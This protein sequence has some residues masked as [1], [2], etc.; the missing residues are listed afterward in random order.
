MG[1][2]PIG[3]TIGL[4]PVKKASVALL[5]LHPGKNA[6]RSETPQIEVAYLGGKKPSLLR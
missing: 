3:S 6:V 1:S 2:I 5:G 4:L